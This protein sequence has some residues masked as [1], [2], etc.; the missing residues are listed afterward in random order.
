MERERSHAGR[1]RHCQSQEY[2]LSVLGLASLAFSVSTIISASASSASAP[3]ALLYYHLLH[4]QYDPLAARQEIAVC[5]VKVPQ[6]NDNFH[7]P[8]AKLLKFPKFHAAR[9]ENLCAKY[10]GDF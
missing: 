7:G 4:S 1:D 2:L 3:I 9:R 5:P 8:L 10:D 6:K